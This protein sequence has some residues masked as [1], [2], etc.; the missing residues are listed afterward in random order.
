MKT[1]TY[2]NQAAQTML[3][4]I[5]EPPTFTFHSRG[6]YTFG[7]TGAQDVVTASLPDGKSRSEEE[8]RGKILDAMGKIRELGV[9][10]ILEMPQLTTIGDQSSGKSSLLESLTM[11]PFPVS[12]ELCT[13]SPTG[14]SLSRSVHPK[15]V[16]SIKPVAPEKCAARPLENI[17][18][19]KSRTWA[20]LNGIDCYIP[21]PN[22]ETKRSLT[23]SNLRGCVNDITVVMSYLE[24]IGVP[25]AN[26]ALLTSTPNPETIFETKPSRWTTLDGGFVPAIKRSDEICYD[27]ANLKAKCPN[28]ARNS[29]FNLGASPQ[30]V[31]I[32]S[33]GKAKGDHF[34]QSYRKLFLG[35]N[36]KRDFH[37][38]P[39]VTVEVS[40]PDERID[41]NFED[42]E[43][44]STKL[45][46]FLLTAEILGLG[47]FLG[48][49]KPES[50]DK[51]IHQHDVGIPLSTATE[52]H[53]LRSHGNYDKKEDKPT[54]KTDLNTP[55]SSANSGGDWNG[56]RN[57][58]KDTNGKRVNDDDQ[59]A[60]DPNR[61][62]LCLDMME[63][64][65]RWGCPFAKAYPDRY[66]HC[67]FI[68]R[69][70][71]SG[72]KQHIGR[73]HN[74]IIDERKLR[75]IKTYESLFDFCIPDWG[76]KL[77]PSHVWN[78]AGLFENSERY[79]AIERARRMSEIEELMV[80]SRMPNPEAALVRYI[81]S[82]LGIEGDIITDDTDMDPPS[83]NQE[84]MGAHGETEI[85][86]DIGSS[87]VQEAEQ[88]DEPHMMPTV[89]EQ[90]R[91]FH[92]EDFLTQGALDYDLGD[93]SKVPWVLDVVTSYKG[94]STNKLSMDSIIDFI[95]ELVPQVVAESEEISEQGPTDFE[96]PLVTM[97]EDKHSTV[98]P[99]S[100]AGDSTVIYMSSS[101]TV[102]SSHSSYP[103]VQTGYTVP[104]SN[105]SRMD[106][107]SYK[108][109]VSRKPAM[110]STV[111]LPGPKTFLCKNFDEA[112]QNLTGWLES[113]FCDPDATFNWEEW[114]LEDT[115][116][117]E[118]VDNIEGV[119][120]QLE[121]D[122]YRH[123]TAK[124]FLVRKE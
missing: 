65:G 3:D 117:K 40:E 44:N 103:V 79:R 74:D 89:G 22:S 115:I 91:A 88:V 124:Y 86:H 4:G 80:I 66:L 83:K 90:S 92:Y 120:N 10:E 8:R 121:F 87:A 101:A 98:P 13:R 33:T 48:S 19:L 60:N 73:Y 51:P 5:H 39:S 108:V 119:I 50:S 77:R 96:Q 102:P 43:K 104:R 2:E 1:S 6:G 54:L 52:L 26:I 70:D 105:A 122:P 110:R 123:A 35:F 29:R 94:P 17:S 21:G 55:S 14:I 69:G 61:K 64:G 49:S 20:L 45:A 42:T 114:R 7:K 9:N 107:S 15:P 63:S 24:S 34:V 12:S 100:V 97:E 32:E 36:P 31:I 25:K 78:F 28:Q 23:Y 11:I 95:P 81:R 58:K 16:I 82:R 99:S 47:A 27:W 46:I 111:E 30:N 38:K 71:L 75:D 112:E 57:G 93:Y 41:E 76:S 67:W 53:Q 109:L 106:R 37:Q 56:K 62:R 85:A 68:N 116:T 72:I 84:Y 118:K 113:K 59:G 18:A